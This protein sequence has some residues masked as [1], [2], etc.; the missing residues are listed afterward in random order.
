MGKR[1]FVGSLP[2]AIT[3]D[4]LREHFAQAGNVETVNIIVDKFTGRAKGF[5]FVEMATDEEAATAINTLNGSN[6]GGRTIVVSE[7]RPMQP[8]DDNPRGGGGGGYNRGR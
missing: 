1:L 4:Q 7:A 3:E 2:Y 6:L 5:G 8:R